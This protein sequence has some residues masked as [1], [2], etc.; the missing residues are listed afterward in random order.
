MAITTSAELQ[1]AVANWLNR[2]DLTS[3]I[4]EFIAL[5][6][7][8]FNRNLRVRAMLNSLAS[9][10]LA[11][12]AV[13]LPTGFLGFKELRY[14]SANGW[15]LEPRPLEWIRNRNESGDASDTPKYFAI[16]GSQVVC[17]GQSGS[18]E[19]SYYKAL[20]SLVSGSSNWLLTSHPD[21]Y[22][23]A[24]LVE[25]FLYVQDPQAAVM[26]REREAAL[27]QEIQ[28]ADNATHIN[29]GPLTIRAR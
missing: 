8:R 24:C 25:G 21:L 22:L 7:A 29:G 11:S 17:S 20:D 23:S 13:S 4:P 19:G 16:T 27:T 18:V 12:G 14:D 6:E 3:R 26:W 5:A 15:T 2:S 9:T 1:T 28:S 10:A